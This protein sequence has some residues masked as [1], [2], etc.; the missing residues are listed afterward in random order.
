MGHR[1]YVAIAAGCLLIAMS[2]TA[3]AE[4][5]GLPGG[6]TLTR[7]G[8]QVLLQAG[9][10]GQ[11]DAGAAKINRAGGISIRQDVP[12]STRLGGKGNLEAPLL[13][14]PGG[15]RVVRK[16][17]EPPPLPQD[18][19]QM[20]FNPRHELDR[21]ELFTGRRVGA[22]K[23]AYLLTPLAPGE[24]DRLYREA[25]ATGQTAGPVIVQNGQTWYLNGTTGRFFPLSGPGIVSLTNQEARFL[26]DLK[27]QVTVKKKAPRDA[28]LALERS[29]RLVGYSFSR[30]MSWA[31]ARAGGSLNFTDAEVAAA[32]GARIRS[33]LAAQQR[34]EAALKAK[35][36]AKRQRE[37]GDGR[38][39]EGG[40]E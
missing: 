15:K 7:Y 19:P 39:A 24:L 8:K 3:R 20:R 34:R 18:A 38:R 25:I 35:Q 28:L 36:D 14:P 5:E 31:L 37:Q 2:T 13:E 6:P 4:E 27:L 29:T 22:G 23:V 26:Q 40:A 32:L 33:G 17:V 1:E 11:Q 12:A 9:L 10:L 21:L 30:E 16:I